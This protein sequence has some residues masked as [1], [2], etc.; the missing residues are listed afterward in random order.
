MRNFAFDRLALH[1]RSLTL[2]LPDRNTPEIIETPTIPSQM[3]GLFRNDP[4]AH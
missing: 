4:S 2:Q 1:A 3:L